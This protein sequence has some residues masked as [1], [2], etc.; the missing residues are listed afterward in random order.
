MVID[1]WGIS[2][3]IA[4]RWLPLDLTDDKLTL[5]HIMACC[6]QATSHYLSQCWLRFMPPYGIIRSQWVK[7]VCVWFV[8]KLHDRLVKMSKYIHVFLACLFCMFLSC[9]F[10]MFCIFTLTF[11]SCNTMYV[12][13]VY[14][15]MIHLDI[16]SS[17]ITSKPLSFVV[18]TTLCAFCILEILEI[19]EAHWRQSDLH[20]EFAPAILTLTCDLVNASL[21][22]KVRSILPQQI[23]LENVIGRYWVAF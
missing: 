2:C 9:I 1:G 15:Y 6:H 3:A 8:K 14:T 20:L 13:I 16:F 19:V 23:K 18:L 12:F 11:F 21:V 17:S 10:C 7:C 22:Q 5:V 4:I